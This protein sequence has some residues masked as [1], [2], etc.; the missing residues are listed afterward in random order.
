MKLATALMEPAS[1]SSCRACSLFFR[2]G[3]PHAVGAR[4]GVRHRRQQFLAAGASLL[5]LFNYVD[6]LLQNR[7]LALKLRHLRFHLLQPRFFRLQVGDVL[8]RGGQLFVLP[9]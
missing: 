3:E 6:A 8:L 5:Q 9:T 7:F 2:R 4:H 1:P